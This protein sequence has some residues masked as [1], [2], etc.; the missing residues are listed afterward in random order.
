MAAIAASAL[1]PTE[2][3]A[4]IEVFKVLEPEVQ[5]GLIG[6]FHLIHNKQKQANAA[7]AAVEAVKAAIAPSVATLA[8]P[9]TKP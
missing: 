9:S 7:T 6:L 8:V 2:I 4:G 3:N 5:K 1:L